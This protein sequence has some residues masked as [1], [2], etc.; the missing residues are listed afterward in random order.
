MYANKLA[1]VLFL[2][3]TLNKV[4]KYLSLELFWIIMYFFIFTHKVWEGIAALYSE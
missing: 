1:Y 2:S 3:F 4:F